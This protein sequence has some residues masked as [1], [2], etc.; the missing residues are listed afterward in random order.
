MGRNLC[1]QKGTSSILFGSYSRVLQIVD[2][3][4]GRLKMSKNGHKFPATTSRR[5]LLKT[6]GAGAAAAALAPNILIAEE[7]AKGKA[8]TV[9][10]GAHTYEWINWGQLPENYKF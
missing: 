8:V 9:G 6:L 1:W 3:F 5:S 7:A 2:A 4:L 10:S